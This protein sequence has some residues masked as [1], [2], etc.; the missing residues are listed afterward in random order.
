MKISKNILIGASVSIFVLV[1]LSLVSYSLSK[2]Q[3]NSKQIASSQIVAVSSKSGFA[4]DETPIKRERIKVGE[5]FAVK[6]GQIFES[7]IM[8]NANEE[9]EITITSV[10]HVY[11]QDI[12]NG[13]TLFQGCYIV[14]GGYI[15]ALFL[16]NNSDQL[17]QL[18]PTIQYDFGDG[19]DPLFGGKNYANEINKRIKLDIANS[20]SKD[21]FVRP[22]EAP[23]IYQIV[24]CGDATTGSTCSVIGLNPDRIDPNIGIS[25]KYLASYSA[26]S[27]FGLNADG[28]GTAEQKISRSIFATTTLLVVREEGE[29]DGKTNHVSIF[30]TKN[31]GEPVQLFESNEDLHTRVELDY[32]YVSLADLSTVTVGTKKFT[33]QFSTG[34]FTKVA[35]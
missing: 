3:S 1:S 9:K 29:R 26:Q 24:Q 20:V 14:S 21:F 22:D 4:Q 15:C 23:Y 5:K 31:A 19:K 10:K 35:Q 13:H 11:L 25:R 33:Y 17:V 30:L 12:G 18:V 28:E 32:D 34:A 6:E 2:Y 8:F 7:N 27:T 16:L